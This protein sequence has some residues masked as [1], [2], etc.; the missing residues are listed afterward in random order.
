[1]NDIPWWSSEDLWRKI[2]IWVTA[3][4]AVVLM[5]LTFDTV[6][7]IT[8]GGERVPSVGDASRPRHLCPF[9]CALPG[10]SERCTPVA[11]SRNANIER[12]PGA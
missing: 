6:R 11:G 7:Q 5:M 8:E 4:M 9:R 3:F 1:M 2:A 12:L 10:L